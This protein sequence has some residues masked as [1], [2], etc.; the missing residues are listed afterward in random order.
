MIVYKNLKDAAALFFFE[1]HGS[2]VPAADQSFGD[3]RI[4]SAENPADLTKE[5]ASSNAK[6]RVSAL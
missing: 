1:A 3:V 6:L 4:L 2:T 5:R